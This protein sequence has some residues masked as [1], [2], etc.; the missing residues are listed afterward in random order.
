MPAG[1]WMRSEPDGTC[2]SN[3]PARRRFQGAVQ[4][5]GRG[6]GL[7]ERAKHVLKGWRVP[8]ARGRRRGHISGAGQTRQGA[9]GPGFGGTRGLATRALGTHAL[10]AGGLA[11]FGLGSRGLGSRGFSLCGSGPYG[12]ELCGARAP[13]NRLC[14]PRTRQQGLARPGG[15]AGRRGAQT[16]RAARRRPA[17]QL[18]RDPEALSSAWSSLRRWR[19]R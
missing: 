8:Q 16:K 18:K 11:P 4:Q 15:L 6:S 12:L 3:G 14:Q 9:A 10:G 19:W 5:A 1:Q 13:W 17:C 2:A 7:L